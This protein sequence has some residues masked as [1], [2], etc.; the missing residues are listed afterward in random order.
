MQPERRETKR[1]SVVNLDLYSQEPQEFIGKV[2]NLSE[3]GLLV[4]TDE[5]YTNNTFLEVRILFD[6]TIDDA[7]NCDFAV[8]VAWSS[9]STQDPSKYSSG[10]EFTEIPELQAHTIQQMIKIYGQN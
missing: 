2:V 1:F 4:M 8:R 5:Q 10:M 6:Q 7:I 9:R 3:G